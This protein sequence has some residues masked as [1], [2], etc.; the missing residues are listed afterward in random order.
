MIEVDDVFRSTLD[1][2]TNVKLDEFSWN[3]TEGRFWGTL[4]KQK[5]DDFCSL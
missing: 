3:L 5:I 1:A 4:V 2:I